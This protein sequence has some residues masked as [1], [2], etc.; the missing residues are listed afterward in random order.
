MNHIIKTERYLLRPI[1]GSDI[2]FIHE[3]LSNPSVT[4][5]YGVHFETLEETK[6]QM[7]WYSNLINENLGIWWCIE[8]LALK[9]LVGAGGYN[10]LVKEIGKAEIG[11][12]VLPNYWGQG[13]MQECFPAIIDY[14]L[15]SL[16]LSRIVGFV[17]TNNDAC[18]RAMSKTN[19]VLEDTFEEFDKRKQARVQIDLYSLEKKE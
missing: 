6:E 2:D 1:V 8:D 18:K 14:G 4:K 12:W 10:N 9:E 7:T 15:T 16:G 19:F 17:E 3:A 13:V 5:Y 11:F